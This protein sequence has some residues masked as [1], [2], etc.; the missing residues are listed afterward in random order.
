MGTQIY[1]VTQM[2][3]TAKVSMQNNLILTE[4]KENQMEETLA[5]TPLVE[6]ASNKKLHNE[7]TQ[8]HHDLAQYKNE[9]VALQ[10]H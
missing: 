3:E 9:L 2:V 10:E 4:D 6:R 7:L 8:V 5:Y 1:F